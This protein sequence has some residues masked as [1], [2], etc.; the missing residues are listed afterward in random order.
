LK[1]LTDKVSVSQVLRLSAV[2]S[3]F[4]ALRATELSPLDTR[5]DD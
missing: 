4:E 2:E 3:R 1:G 5:H